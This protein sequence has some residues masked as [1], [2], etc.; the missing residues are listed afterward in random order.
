VVIT[1]EFTVS[2]Q[3]KYSFLFFSRFPTIQTF[4][5]STTYRRALPDSKTECR[6]PRSPTVIQN[7]LLNCAVA[8]CSMSM[9]VQPSSSCNHQNLPIM[10]SSEGGD[11]YLV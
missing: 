4:S 5:P 1:L 6:P 9:R 7:L 3:G 11:W 2:C 10:S 8:G